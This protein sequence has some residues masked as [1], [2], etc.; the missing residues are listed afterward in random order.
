MIVDTVYE[1]AP[2]S[3]L[4]VPGPDG[5]FHDFGF[6][7]LSNISDDIKAEL[8]EDCRQA[9]EEALQKEMQWKNRWGSEG[10]SG[11]RRAPIIDKGVV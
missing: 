6:N 8:P 10:H 2:A 1:S 3:N 7:G 4:G 9:F 5:D 11:H